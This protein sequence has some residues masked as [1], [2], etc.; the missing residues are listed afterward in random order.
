MFINLIPFIEKKKF[1]QYCIGILII[2]LFHRSILIMIPFYFFI[3]KPIFLNRVFQIALILF[4]FSASQ[5][6]YNYVTNSIFPYLLQYLTFDD[7][8]GYLGESESLLMGESKNSLGFALIIFLIIDCVVVLFSNRMRTYY[9]TIP[10][11]T[12]YNFYFIG[13]LLTFI[14]K[15]LITIMRINMY[16]S[17]F[18][19]FI[20]ALLVHWLFIN[21]KKWSICLGLFICCFGLLWFINAI[22][23]G[24]DMYPYDFFFYHI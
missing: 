11:N 19:F 10:F 15:N 2:S 5:F 4:F 12:L 21:N 22:F 24:T 7:A 8:Q 3:N 13:I 9:K 1:M 17:S 18:R 14:A 20:Y 6:I 23:K 16:F